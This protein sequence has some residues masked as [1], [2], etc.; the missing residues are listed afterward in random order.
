MKQTTDGT[1]LLWRFTAHP[2][3]VGQTYA[4]HAAFAATFGVRL[5]GAGC[6][7][8]VHAALPFLFVTTASRLIKSLHAQLNATDRR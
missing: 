4:Q 6:A 8:L 2:A 1:R 7:A 3:A 5:L